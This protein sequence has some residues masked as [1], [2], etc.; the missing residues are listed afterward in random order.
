MNESETNQHIVII[1]E[2]FFDISTIGPFTVIKI[3]GIISNIINLYIFADPSFDDPI[4]IYLRAHS[5]ADILYMIGVL[6]CDISF[7]IHYV[8]NRIIKAFIIKL[9]GL[10]I[11]LY[12]TSCLAI[13][14]ILIE[15]IVSFQRFLILKNAKYCKCIRTTTPYIVLPIIALFSLVVYLHEIIFF[16]VYPEVCDNNG[17]NGTNSTSITDEQ[18]FYEI[19]ANELG[20]IYGHMYDKLVIVVQMFRGPFCLV[21]MIIVNSMTW[22]HFKKYMAKKAK[23]KGCK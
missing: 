23:I 20:L 12:F 5:I 15:L 6:I 10:Y 1:G 17:T 3:Y 4:Y 2:K 18:C 19:R 9:A 13:F 14:N 8:S 22:H 16:Q 7:L 11:C 21:L